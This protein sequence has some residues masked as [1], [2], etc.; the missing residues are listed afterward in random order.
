MP[1]HPSVP[2][3]EKRMCW[4]MRFRQHKIEVRLLLGYATA[5]QG[6]DE[7][8]SPQGRDCPRVFQKPLQEGTA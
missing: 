3:E 6:G 5:G 7:T 4:G 8:P 1:A 2:M